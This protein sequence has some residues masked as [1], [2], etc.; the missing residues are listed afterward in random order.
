MGKFNTRVNR[1]QV[2][3]EIFK[4]FLSFCPYDKDVIDEPPP[5]EMLERSVFNGV[6]FKFTHEC[7]ASN[8]IV[9]VAAASAG[10][11]RI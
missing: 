6:L 3:D 5:N 10:V 2:S 9:E 4:V 7:E 11:E 1:V 8:G